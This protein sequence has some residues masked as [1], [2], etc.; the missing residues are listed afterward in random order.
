MTK[1]LRALLSGVH[2]RP[3]GHP[4]E[5]AETP[6][7]FR[8]LPPVTGRARLG[9]SHGC[10][11]LMRHTQGPDLAASSRAVLYPTSGADHYAA[12]GGPS[13]STSMRLIC[14]WRAASRS[15]TGAPRAA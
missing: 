15:T 1:G 12:R 10:S 8:L 11:Q 14:A 13:T 6:Q 3:G 4:S 7:G 2:R 5:F 9:C